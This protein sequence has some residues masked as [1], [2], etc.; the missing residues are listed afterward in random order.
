[1]V[2]AISGIIIVGFLGDVSQDALLV[3]YVLDVLGSSD[4]LFLDLLKGK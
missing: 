4:T 3:F 1:M 2:F